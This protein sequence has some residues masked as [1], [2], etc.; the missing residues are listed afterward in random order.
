M[1]HH[2]SDAA[3][4][5]RGLSHLSRQ[6]FN[7]A[8]KSSDLPRRPPSSVETLAGMLSSGLDR[9]GGMS[10]SDTV[11]KAA[12]KSSVL[13]RQTGI[14]AANA[15][16]S[17]PSAVTYGSQP[18]ADRIVIPSHADVDS[19]TSTPTTM[20][21]PD[22]IPIPT[23]PDI[24]ASIVKTATVTTSVVQDPI[25]IPKHPGIQA[26]V[27]TMPM[28]PRLDPFMPTKPINPTVSTLSMQPSASI[29][30]ISSV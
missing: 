27:R 22:P 8:L 17:P 3:R 2:L 25:P 21:V 13:V 11:S 5:L 6:V 1:S 7:A 24:D 4:F 28:E 26:T 14:A 18:V 16:R 20:P 19:I 9:L 23:H 29:G 10:V 12:W 15:I 30:G